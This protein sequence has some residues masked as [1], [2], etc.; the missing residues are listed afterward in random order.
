MNHRYK[1]GQSMRLSGAPRESN[2]PSGLCT[3]VA[4]LP[5]ERGPVLYRIKS[6]DENNERVV[7][8]RDL[9]PVAAAVASV[10]SKAL[11]ELFQIAVSK[12]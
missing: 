3:V 4:C 10:N 9:T 7:E 11:N 5:H 6:E 2:R 8:E 12:R 1:T